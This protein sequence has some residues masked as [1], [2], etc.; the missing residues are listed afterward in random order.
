MKK[1]LVPTDLT[2]IAELG[3]KL[4]VEI[5]RRS[6]AIISLVNFTRHPFGRTFTAMG[7]VNLKVD[8]EGTLYTLQLLQATK[9]KLQALADQYRASGVNIE[10]SVV[11]DELKNGVDEY[12]QREEIDL[13]V[14]GTSGEENAT[15][16]FKGNHTE[17]VIKVSSC[18]VLSVRDGFIIENFS[19]M[20][21]AVNVIEDNQ[22]A[23]GLSTLRR[24]AECFDAHIHLVHIHDSASD[25]PPILEEYFVKMAQAA[26]LKHYF[27]TILE[28]DDPAE[29][30]IAFSRDVRA[31]LIAVI[32][33]SRDGLFRIFSNHFSDRLVK[34][35]GRPVFT[36]NL[37]N[38]PEEV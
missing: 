3:L 29:A 37:Q 17:Q 18:P 22:V 34:E 5:A 9:A 10:F 28:A 20:V 23:Q 12:L 19:N 21:V 32:K 30:I 14:M 11:D 16:L 1:L 13:I 7:D 26:G 4:A 6:Q 25:S 8:E 36:Y 24:L 35:V 2:P 38:A 31:G 15:E 27:I 33:N